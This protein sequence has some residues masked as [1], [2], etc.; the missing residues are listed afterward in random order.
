MSQAQPSPG[1]APAPE[2]RNIIVTAQDGLP[3]H[4]RDYRPTGAL[5][6]G[7]LPV[8]CLPGLTRTTRDFHALAMRL[9]RA[10]PPRR[11][12]A[13]DL[14][15]R[16][17]SGHD[18]DGANY[19]PHREALDILDMTAALGIGECVVVGTS[20]GG[21]VAMVMAL[22]RPGLLRGVLL[23]DIGPQIEAQGLMR[24]AA[25]L[26]SARQPGDWPEATALV[27]QMYQEQFTDLTDAQWSDFA[28]Q[29]FAD[30]KARPVRD[31]DPKVADSLNS[32]DIADGKVP[33]LWAMFAGLGPVAVAVVR[34]ENSDILS[35]ETVARMRRE[36]PKLIVAKAVNRGHAPFLTEP[37]SIKA[38][39]ELLARVDPG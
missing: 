11:V 22:L 4:G 15:G 3:L 23:N 21:I 28:H 24:I 17:M 39:D 36:H 30:D 25:Q 14:R 18:A 6:A 27:R 26:K 5:V 38:L 33:E 13:F 32:Q 8:V 7:R 31:Y 10:A 12:L 1:P 20:R 29:I 9:S 34:G 19:T 35:A 37:E 2:W 16:G